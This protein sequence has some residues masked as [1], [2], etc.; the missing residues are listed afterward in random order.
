MDTEE[1]LLCKNARV[2]L[3]VDLSKVFYF[4]PDRVRSVAE[5]HLIPGPNDDYRR[6]KI[7]DEREGSILIARKQANIRKAEKESK[8][9]IDQTKIDAAKAE[10][11]EAWPEY[12]N[13]NASIHLSFEITGKDQQTDVLILRDAENVNEDGLLTATGFDT[14][15]FSHFTTKATHNKTAKSWMR[16]VMIRDVEDDKLRHFLLVTVTRKE[17]PITIFYREIKDNKSMMID[18][19]LDHER[20]AWQYD[21]IITSKV[22]LEGEPDET[23]DEEPAV[24]EPVTIEIAETPHKNGKVEAECPDCETVVRIAPR[25]LGK[26]KCKTCQTVLV[27]KT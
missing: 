19:K 5:I 22:Q 25:M 26:T 15:Q 18:Y 3:V 8:A 11:S 13:S 14:D 7:Y 1:T 9:Y 17:T 21:G 2:Q 27:A 12:L 16:P 23:V 6:L 4:R 20:R 24:A 10:I